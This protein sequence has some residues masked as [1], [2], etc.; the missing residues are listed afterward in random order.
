MSLRTELDGILK[1]NYETRLA[2]V[3]AELPHMRLGDRLYWC[4]A[5]FAEIILACVRIGEEGG[6]AVSETALRLSSVVWPAGDDDRGLTHRLASVGRELKAGGYDHMP[7][8]AT[9][10]LF[11]MLSRLALDALMRTRPP[12]GVSRAQKKLATLVAF[13]ERPPAY[14]GLEDF[15]GNALLRLYDFAAEFNTVA[16]EFEEIENPPREEAPPM[17]PAAEA[18]RRTCPSERTRR[19]VWE[20][21]RSCQRHPETLSAAVEGRKVYVKDAWEATTE[22]ERVKYNVHTLADFTRIKQSV[23]RTLNRKG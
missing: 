13:L 16:R 22:A 19:W 14:F 6:P 7:D 18:P 1:A 17:A 9:W 15:H 23:Q 11:R 4:C 12:P 20:K 10:A 8:T 5:G 21:W 2:C 3:A